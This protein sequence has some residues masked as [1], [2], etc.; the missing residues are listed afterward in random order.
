M[1]LRI[2][3]P[4]TGE[5]RFRPLEWKVNNRGYCGFF[6]VAASSALAPRRMSTIA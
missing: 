3:D 2:V 4:S 6:G 1:D 5:A